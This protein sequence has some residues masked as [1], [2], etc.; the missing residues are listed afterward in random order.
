L[1]LSLSLSFNQLKSD[2]PLLRLVS[3]E[4]CSE[5]LLR[6]P[7]W[8]P[9]QATRHSSPTW[10]KGVLGFAGAGDVVATIGSGALRNLE[11]K[12][13]VPSLMPPQVSDTLAP[14][15]L[16]SMYRLMIRYG[17]NQFVFE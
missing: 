14:M 15:P 11:K 6:L 9:T 1:L 2:G 4:H 16:Q 7:S 13:V 5:H 10:L 12:P 8:C 3:A 17:L